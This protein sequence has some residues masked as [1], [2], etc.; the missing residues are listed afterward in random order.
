MIIIVALFSFGCDG[1]TGDFSIDG[2]YDLGTVRFVYGQNNTWTLRDV[3]V[4]VDTSQGEIFFSGI[5]GDGALWGYSGDYDRDDDRLVALDL[6]EVDFG[7]EDQ[8][9]LRIEF[10]SNSRF[11]GVAINWVYDAGEL[12]DVGAA[13]IAGRETFIAAAE[14]REVEP[15]GV[16]DKTSKDHIIQR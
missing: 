12:T 2:D 1:G 7:S 15:A 3:I 6:P 5:D 10:T 14:A 4:T 16:E 13:N 9:D 8:L 11:E